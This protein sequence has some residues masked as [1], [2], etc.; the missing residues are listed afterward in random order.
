MLI[1][2]KTDHNLFF[3]CSL[4]EYIGRKTHNKRNSIVNTIGEKGLHHLYNFADVLHCENIDEV[5]E[6]LICQYHITEGDFDNITSCEYKVP[7]HWDM[8]KVY[9]RLIQMVGGEPIQTLSTIY[10]SWLAEKLD[11]YNIAVYF[12]SPE[13]I[14]ECYK[15]NEILE[16]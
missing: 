14:F 2:V 8:G 6:R 13:Y 15:A 3:L 10:N 1:K 12:M 9:Q 4:I 16:D 5:T 7:T 11:N